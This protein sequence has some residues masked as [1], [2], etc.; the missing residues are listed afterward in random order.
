MGLAGRSDLASNCPEKT[1]SLLLGR[2]GKKAGE[3]ASGVGVDNGGVTVEGEAQHRARSVRADTRE[4]GELFKAAGKATA[5]FHD[6]LL[7]GALQVVSPGIIPESLPRLAHFQGIGVGE[8][9]QSGVALEEFFVIQER[10]LHL[11]LL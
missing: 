11:G 6:N 3:H 10:P 2:Q 5:V 9:F 1:P 8:L 7:G 4:R